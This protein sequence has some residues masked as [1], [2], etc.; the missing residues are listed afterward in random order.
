MT[1]LLDINMK[2]N[3]INHDGFHHLSRFLK[4]GCMYYLS[5]TSNHLSEDNA[6]TVH[7]PFGTFAEQLKSNTTLKSLWLQDCDLHSRSAKVLAD[8]LTTNRHLEELILSNNRL[9]DDGIEHLAHCLR[10]NQALKKVYLSNCDMT[11]VGLECLATSLQCN[12]AMNDLR[13]FS[14]Y[15]STVHGGWPNKFTERIVPILIK[16]FQNNCTLTKLGLPRNLESST[17]SIE[18]AVNDARRRG[19]LPFIKV[20]GKL[21]MLVFSLESMYRDNNNIIRMHISG[22][23]YMYTQ[24]I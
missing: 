7:T 1:S 6:G 18:K 11:D 8:A 2:F 22:L 23:T 14:Y 24:Y 13:L 21:C 12:S 15:N 19:G 17:A 10:I 5:L 20:S 3:E 9:R 16:C 4:S